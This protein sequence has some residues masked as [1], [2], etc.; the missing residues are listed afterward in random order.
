MFVDCRTL[1]HSAL[2]S[3]SL[4]DLFLLYLLY[5]LILWSY[6]WLQLER[7]SPE[8][9]QGDGRLRRLHVLLHEWVWLLP[10]GARSFRGCVPR[11]R[12]ASPS[13]V[14]PPVIIFFRNKEK[15][16]Q[17][18]FVISHV[19]CT[20]REFLIGEW[21]AA[22]RRAAHHH[23]YSVNISVLSWMPNLTQL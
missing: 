2:F 18:K 13:R 22:R 12:V 14:L 3:Q 17:T 6:L 11:I 7:T 20:P 19:Y 5:F 23:F 8:V 10:Q 9:P 4:C 1:L 21:I 16:R 15:S